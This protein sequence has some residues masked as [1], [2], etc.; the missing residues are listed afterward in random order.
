MDGDRNNIVIGTAGHVDHGKTALVKVLTGIDTDRLKE[1]KDRGMTIEPG[2]A[3]MEL[4]SGKLVSIVDVPGHER[5]IKNMLRGISGVDIALLVVASDDG[6][7]PQTRE[8]LDILR[9]L[10]VRCGLVV[11]SKVDLV[12]DEVIRMAAEEVE[13]LVRGTFLEDAPVVP[14]SARTGQGIEEITRSIENIAEQVVEKDRDGVFRLPIDRVF[15]MA[16]Y[17]TIVT[18]TIASGS[19]RKGD[20]V[21]VYPTGETTTVR[22]IQSSN[23]WINEAT[24]G[25]RVGLNLH[26]I[27]VEDL[28]RGF[29]LGEPRSL[30]SAHLI[31]AK[32]QYLR[33]NPR[34]LANRTKVRFY[35]GTSEVV[36]RIIFVDKEKL[37]PGESCFVQF[38]L[39]DK[40]TLLPYDRYVIRSLSPMS[41]IG[42]GIVLEINPRKYRSIQAEAAHHLEVL[43]RR[44]GHE[45][46]EALT[47]KERF[48]PIRLSEAAKRLR[49]TQAEVESA[50]NHLLGEGRIL[51]VED[52]SVIHAE[53]RARL[54]RETIEKIDD[55]HEGHPNVR[56]TSQEEI[57]C[58]ISPLFDRRLYEAILLE[59][60]NERK[61]EIQKGRIKA[62]GFQVTLS[63]K[64]QK[65]YEH[66]DGVCRAYLLRPMPSPDLKEVGE[67]YGEKEVEAI[68]GLM[69]GERRLIKLNNQRLIHSE[70]IEEVKRRLKEHIGKKGRFVLGDSMEVLGLGRTQVQPILEYLDAI[71]F[72]MRIGDFRVLH[73]DVERSLQRQVM[74]DNFAR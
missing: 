59:L 62:A 65:I 42:G 48:G 11:L 57:R 63:E 74:N 1:E 64:Q 14:F 34:P 55:F 52:G 36:A 30:A 19:V 39:E 50:C 45:M 37:H 71:R 12:D 18:G 73:K 28:K 33:S 15:T 41:T 8:H 6:V 3:Y 21:Q 24:A 46:F 49:L 20:H 10:N 17:G 53:S 13:S 44:I 29:V 23:R 60:K 16:G 68:V 9:L 4:R 7:M 38:R 47:K 25:R 26:N 22:N 51:L 2:F 72:T 66:V 5:F 70:A 43:E 32:F 56:D 27:R 40:V 31:N 61:I 35:S 69:I 67:R 54:K 58:K